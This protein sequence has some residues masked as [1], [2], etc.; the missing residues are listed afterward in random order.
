MLARARDTVLVRV[1]FVTK[2]TVNNFNCS[3]LSLN[4]R[5]ITNRHRARPDVLIIACV[6]EQW[7]CLHER[8]QPARND[9]VVASARL[10]AS[11]PTA[12]LY[13][14]RPKRHHS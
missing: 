5:C 12:L 4:C 11:A 8:R 9:L 7:R 2:R 10:M 14:L 1:Q 3:P 6:I 13:C